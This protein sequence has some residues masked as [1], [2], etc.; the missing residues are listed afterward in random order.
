[1]PTLLPLHQELSGKL[2][3]LIRA[4]TFPAGSRFPSIRHT[5]REHRVSISTVMEAY[6]H[7]EDEGHIE[8]RPRS[9]YF[10]APPKI[11]TDRFPTTARKAS[12]PLKVGSIV[13][14][15]MDTAGNPDFVPFGTAAP[16]DGIVPESKLAVITREVMRKHGAGALRYTPPQGRR[17]L[18]TALSRRLYDIGL[19]VAPDEI[20]TTQG[21][22]EG[23]LLALRATTKTGD[24]VAVE[25]PSYFGTLNL[26]RDLGL[27]VIEIPVDPR[28]GMVIDALAA[29]LKKHTIA[30]CIVQPHFQNPI[31]SVMPESHK[32]ALADLAEAHDFTIIED[33]V[34]GDLSHDGIRP[35]SIAIHSDRVIHCGS[36]SK[37]IAPG[38]R[39]GWLVPGSHLAEIRRLKGIQC[40]W[41]GTLSELVIAGFLDAGGYDRHLRRIRG[42]YAE[43]CAR[44]REAVLQH[45]PDYARV[46]HP[47]G[48]F[49]LWVEMPAGFDSQA[50]T[51][52]ALKKGISLSPGTIFSA[53][54]GL[55]HCFRLS[56]GFAFGER[57]LEAIATLGQL[58]PHHRS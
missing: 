8:A 19:K 32:K 48:G 44:S 37:T 2:A 24:V 56:C 43:Q 45:F 50:F 31:G 18:R 58:A 4:G 13:E 49:V 57:T 28:T 12:R 36:V 46:N 22:T 25:S 7:L 6:R 33:D 20:V 16:G 15:I 52:A 21:A 38:L 26:I 30:A 27:R 10:V 41:N 55:N 35:P 17:E 5:S 14:T 1:M 11:S 40:P 51:Q 9:G 42:L 3:G 23:I 29:A 39:V 54:G 53:S 47:A 34:Y